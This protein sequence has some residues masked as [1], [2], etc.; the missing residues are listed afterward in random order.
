MPQNKVFFNDFLISIKE[1]P[2]RDWGHQLD[3]QS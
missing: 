1:R 2:G 3:K